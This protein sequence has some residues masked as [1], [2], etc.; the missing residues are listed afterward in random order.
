M[1]DSVQ[2]AVP[3]QSNSQKKKFVASAAQ[4]ICLMQP[5]VISAV[6]G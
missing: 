2:G 5:F 1:R 3:R 4:K 6:I